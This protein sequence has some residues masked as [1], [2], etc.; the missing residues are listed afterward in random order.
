MS[1]CASVCNR[2]APGA[3]A[4]AT[5]RKFMSPRK[6]SLFSGHVPCPGS[7][8]IF[9]RGEE[10]EKVGGVIDEVERGRE[11][12]LICWMMIGVTGIVIGGGGVI[13]VVINFDSDAIRFFAH[14]GGF[15]HGKNRN[16][17]FA[18]EKGSAI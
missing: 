9:T 2:E 6:S 1:E 17:W 3:V 12:G 14:G 18:R 15:V 8:K 7:K 10:K 16:L 5:E 11:I 4:T 13:F